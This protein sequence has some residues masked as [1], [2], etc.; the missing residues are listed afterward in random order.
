ME[1]MEGRKRRDLT[2]RVMN[3]EY[4]GI[5]S[6]YWAYYGVLLS[7][8]SIYL[9]GKGFS[10]YEIGLLFALA[11]I[12]GAVIQPPIADVV[13]HAEKFRVHRMLELLAVVMDPGPGRC[14]GALHGR[15]GAG[16]SGLPDLLPDCR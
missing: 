1:E 15:A 4:G 5:W 16:S 2:A 13:D 10:N 8:G 9:L 7:F 6:M 12:F 11:G 3:I 14:K